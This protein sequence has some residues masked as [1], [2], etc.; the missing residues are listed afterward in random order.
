[1]G[2]IWPLTA[3][4]MG[5]AVSLPEFGF[6]NYSIGIVI[7]SRALDPMI[8]GGPFSPKNYDSQNTSHF[9]NDKRNF[10]VDYV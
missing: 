8:H 9:T 3:Y 6:L 1:M 7:S 2:P 5:L 4:V 10:V